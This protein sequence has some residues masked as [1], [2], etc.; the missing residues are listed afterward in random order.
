LLLK[1]LLE[2]ADR[3][4]GFSH[5][6]G[7]ARLER[8]T[9]KLQYMKKEKE[10]RLHGGEDDSVTMMDAEEKTL[11]KEETKEELPL[12]G[13]SKVRLRGKITRLFRRRDRAFKSTEV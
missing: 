12:D 1:I 9:K 5:L 4:S 10:R 11:V 2:Y 3:L 8:M 6:F 13:D 7:E